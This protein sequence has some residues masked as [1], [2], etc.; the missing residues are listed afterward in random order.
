MQ[1]TDVIEYPQNQINPFEPMLQSFWDIWHQA[2]AAAGG[3]IPPRVSIKVSDLR[4][5]TANS[6]T[7]ERRDDGHFYVR[8]MGSNLEK[9]FDA[10]LTGRPF[11]SVV[12]DSKVDVVNQFFSAVIDRPVAAYSR[13]IITTQDGRKL[14]STALA[15]PL[16]NRFGERVITMSVCEL[17]GIG[18]KVDGPF[19]S[20]TKLDY[21]EV[22]DAYF[23]NLG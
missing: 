10:P 6:F 7:M 8:M 13:E 20:E 19:A 21:T 14:R 12:E 9:I 15:L 18:F 23:I 2:R 1:I 17:V 16:V 4:S 3:G 5:L 11:T 22:E